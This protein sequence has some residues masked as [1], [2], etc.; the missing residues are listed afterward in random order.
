MQA[1]Y[2]RRSYLIYEDKHKV[3]ELD[4]TRI[5]GEFAFGYQWFRLGDTYLRY[6]YSVDSTEETLGANPARDVI[7][8]GSLAFLTTF[9][10]RDRDTFPH[11]GLLV[12]G[13]YESAQPGYGST[14]EFAKIA[15]SI[16]GAI[17]IA[18]RHTLIL[19]GTGGLGSGNIPYQEK[20][21][22]GGVDYL[23]GF[24]LAGYQRREFTGSDELGF[25]A[26]YRWTIK[27]YRLK[28]VKAVYLNLMG[29]AANVWD[30]RDEVSVDHLRT[31][32]GIGLHADTIIGPMRLDFGAGSGHR[33]TVYFSAGYD[34]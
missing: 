25:S 6:R 19:E 21:G 31:G 32:A 7:H 34:F 22:I 18:E 27:E 8:I 17:P 14:N 4:I 1:L 28:A 16:Q 3:N 10:T 15:L 30:S 20:F 13:S 12:K 2:Q 11:T 23:L 29:Q 24:P 9:D 33:N 26:A 5:G